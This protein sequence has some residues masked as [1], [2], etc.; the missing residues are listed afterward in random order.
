[1][2]MCL[3]TDYLGFDHLLGLVS[4]EH[5]FS[6]RLLLIACNSSSMGWGQWYFFYPCWHV[7]WCHYAGLVWVMVLLRFYGESFPVICGIACPCLVTGV[8]FS[9][10]YNLPASLL[11]CPLSLRCKGCTVAIAFWIWHSGAGCYLHL[12][13]LSISVVVSVCWKHMFLWWGARAA[14]TCGC[15]DPIVL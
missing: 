8:W 13:Q 12:D 2:Y 1:M 9:G 11:P 6:S 4:G 15:P 10:S 3:G 5:W 7:N 14:L